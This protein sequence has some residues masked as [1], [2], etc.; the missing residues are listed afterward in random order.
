MYICC[1]HVQNKQIGIEG[2]PRVPSAYNEVSATTQHKQAKRDCE[3]EK[4]HTPGTP[5]MSL[6]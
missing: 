1:L 2:H 4:L 3:N 6:W 5:L